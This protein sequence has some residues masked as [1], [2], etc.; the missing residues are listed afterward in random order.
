MTDHILTGVHTV[1]SLFSEEH[2]MY[3]RN[4][5]FLTLA[6]FTLSVPGNS[7]QPIYQESENYLE[8]TIKSI[9]I[10]IIQL[11]KLSI[12]VSVLMFI[13]YQ[14]GPVVRQSIFLQL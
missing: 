5:C 10:N 11:C 1:L 6:N 4:Q 7:Q 12:I 8:W 14:L 9:K 13:Y 2:T 3:S